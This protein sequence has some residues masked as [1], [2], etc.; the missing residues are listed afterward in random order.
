VTLFLLLVAFEHMVGTTVPT[1]LEKTKLAL[2][3]HRFLLLLWQ[4]DQKGGGIMGEFSVGQ[5]LGVPSFWA[6]S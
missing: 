5:G 3:P 1:F 6:L 4:Q 2:S